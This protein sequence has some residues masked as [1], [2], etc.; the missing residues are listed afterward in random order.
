MFRLKVQRR[1]ERL[2]VK[3]V[4]KDWKGKT[5]KTWTKT[6]KERKGKERKGK[7]IPER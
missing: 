6:E 7:E 4:G 5:G 3:L 2:I 1:R